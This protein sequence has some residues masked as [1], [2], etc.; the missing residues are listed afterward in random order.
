[1]S[2]GNK[3]RAIA[4]LSCSFLGGFRKFP[5]IGSCGSGA[6]IPNFIRSHFRIGIKASSVRP[7]AINVNLKYF[8]TLGYPP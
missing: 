2:H 4:I 1:M 8:L 5:K 7:S 3:S 6:L